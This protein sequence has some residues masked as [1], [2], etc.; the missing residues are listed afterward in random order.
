VLRRT[1]LL[2][3][4]LTCCLSF[5]GLAVLIMACPSAERVFLVLCTWACDS[6]RQQPCSGQYSPP[7]ESWREMSEL[8]WPQRWHRT[9][10]TSVNTVGAGGD[11]SFCP[12][13]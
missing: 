3:P 7:L 4:L 8:P 2:W 12:V 5:R 11:F 13:L 10:T 1:V 6:P 9:W